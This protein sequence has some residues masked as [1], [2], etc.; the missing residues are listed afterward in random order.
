MKKPDYVYVSYIAATPEKVWQAFIDT[1]IMREYWVGP[2]SDC[3]RV[4]VSD[5]KIGSKWEHQ[6]TDGS[7]IVDIIGKV[8]E[9]RPHSR[10][11]LSWARPSEEEDE[12]KHSR[13]SIDIEAITGGTVRLTVTHD[14]LDEQMLAGIS[15]GWPKVLSNLKTLLET[16]KPLPRVAKAA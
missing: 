4:N 2:G 5:W 15:G 14:G 11:V 3:S 8:L 12:S 9:F 1:D 7:G 6:R 16:G 13:V 10:M